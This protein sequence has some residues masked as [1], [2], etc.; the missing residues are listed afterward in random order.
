MELKYIE[1][2]LEDYNAKTRLIKK[3]EEEIKNLKN[4]I[5]KYEK[6]VPTARLGFQERVLFK[7]D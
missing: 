3:Q 5:A 4:E 2:S 6:L 7:K 1:V